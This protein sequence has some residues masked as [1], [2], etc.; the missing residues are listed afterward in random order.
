MNTRIVTIARHL[1]DQEK[2]FPE[3][4]GEFTSLMWDLT[5]AFKII[6][7]E[8]N[9]AGLAQYLGLTGEENVHGEKLQKLDVFAHETIFRAMD[10]G[11]HLCVMA[12][13]EDPGIIAIPSKFKKG[14]YVLLYDPLDGS[15]NIDVNVSIGSIFSILRKRT[16]GPDGTL[17]DCLQPGTEQVAAGYVVYGSSTMLVYT[18]C[19]GVNGFTLDPEI[20]EFLLS[21]PHI[22]TPEYGSIYSIN[23]GYSAEWDSGTQQYIHSLKG[24]KSPQGKAYSMRYIGS[25]VA[26]F[27]RNLLQ[28]GIFL[29]PASCKDPTKP[30]PKLRLLYEA[31]PL[32]LIVEQAGGR[33]STGAQRIL[34]IVPTSL[35]QRVPLVLGSAGDVLTYEK[36]F[37]G[38]ASGIARS[39]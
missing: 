29:Y 33:S 11:G 30:K 14:K 22:K 18:T 39:A 37:Q 20:G 3:A 38:A 36:F 15:S 19:Q 17:D 35:H 31:N 25:L 2:N 21:H 5:I 32:S 16:S 24:Q 23:E 27:H 13:E 7:K 4:T 10:H 12:S 26:D 6:S 9:R 34:E 1:V 8:V 28:G